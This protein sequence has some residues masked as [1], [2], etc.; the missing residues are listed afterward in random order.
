[1]FGSSRKMAVWKL[2]NESGKTSQDG[3]LQ[4]HE[5]GAINRPDRTVGHH[6]CQSR[7]KNVFVQCFQRIFFGEFQPFK[8]SPKK[9][10]M[11]SNLRSA[12]FF[13]DHWKTPH[14]HFQR[15]FRVEHVHP[16]PPIKKN[17]T[18]TEGGRWQ[19]VPSDV[20]PRLRVS[21]APFTFTGFVTLKMGEADGRHGVIFE[22][23]L[24]RYFLDGRLKKCQLFGSPNRVFLLKWVFRRDQCFGMGL[25]PQQNPAYSHFMV[26]DF[27]GTSYLQKNQWW[28][29]QQQVTNIFLSPQKKN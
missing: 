15:L 5:N 28:R 21:A 13:P 19:I 24:E 2:F 17:T 14:H 6:V 27:Q 8:C 12:P 29:A 1:M 4:I 16:S 18:Q 9:M 25:F 10:R 20:V 7:N 11:D 22:K 26:F 23:V 3:S